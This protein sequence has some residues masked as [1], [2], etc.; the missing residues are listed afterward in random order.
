MT[1]SFLNKDTW[2]NSFLLSPADLNSTSVQD[3]LAEASTRSGA[4]FIASTMIL[5]TIRSGLLG[6]LPSAFGPCDGPRALL[7]RPGQWARP[8]PRQAQPNPECV[9]PMRGRY[10]CRGPNIPW[11]ER[12]TGRDAGFSGTNHCEERLPGAGHQ[13]TLL[14]SGPRLPRPGWRSLTAAGGLPWELTVSNARNQCT[15]SPNGC[16]GPHRQGTSSI[17]FKV[18]VERSRLVSPRETRCTNW[19][20]MLPAVPFI[21]VPQPGFL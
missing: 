2:A 9:L 13:W 8:P 11:Q 4:A 15:A 19:A 1:D 3:D 20:A 18:S 5:E 17:R 7:F 6:P 14:P 12:V 21:D 10:L 16:S